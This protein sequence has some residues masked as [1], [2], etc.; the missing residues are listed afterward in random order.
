MFERLK[1]DLHRFNYNNVFEKA[2]LEAHFL[3]AYK[4]TLILKVPCCKSGLSLGI[5]FIGSKVKDENLVRHEYGHRLQ[6]KKIGFLGYMKKVFFP[7][8][9]A[10][11][12]ERLGKLPYDYYGSPWE[13]EADQLGDVKRKKSVKTWPEDACRSYK[14]LLKLLKKV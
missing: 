14:D 11:I 10:N 12:L 6:L 4:R 2:V 7:S 1:A 8:V 3:S 13:T 5:I 9:T